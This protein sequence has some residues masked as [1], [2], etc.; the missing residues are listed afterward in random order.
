ML[1]LE[2]QRLHLNATLFSLVWLRS[3]RLVV[4]V[5]IF[6]LAFVDAII[7]C[8]TLCQLSVTYVKWLTLRAAK[9]DL[10]QR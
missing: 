8:H 4:F 1:F 3:V 5:C 9:S 6:M 2:R 7:Q 10:L